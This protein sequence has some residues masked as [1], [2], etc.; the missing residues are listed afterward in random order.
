MPQKPTY[1]ELEQKIKEL[2]KNDDLLNIFLIT[3]PPLS[4]FVTCYTLTKKGGNCYR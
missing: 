2:E 3:I 1:K 4:Y